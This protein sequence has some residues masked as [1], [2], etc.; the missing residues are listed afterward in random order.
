MSLAE[1]ERI[2]A[3]VCSQYTFAPGAERTIEMNPE[4]A[5][6]DKLVGLRRMGFN[7]VS[8][9]VQ[10]FHEEA[11]RSI[12]RSHTVEKA[13]E[14]VMNAQKAGF[15]NVSVDLILGLP[16]CGVAEVREDVCRAAALPVTHVSVYML[17]I[18][19]GSVLER[20][21]AKGLFTPPA[22]D[23]LA[24]EYRTASEILREN[25]FEHYE[26]SN[27]AREGKRAVHNMN[28][29]RGLPYI[30]FG[31]AAHSYDGTSRQWN[32]AHVLS[33]IKGINK[34]KVPFE[35]EELSDKD[36]YNEYVMTSLRTTDGASLQKLTD[37]YS[38]YWCQN[39]GIVERFIQKG[40]MQQKG[41]ILSLSE[42]GWLL[43]DAIYRDLF[44]V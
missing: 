23:L 25:G 7:R 30:G 29:W 38:K 19:S 36:I 8:I 6:M 40:W 44:V 14:S 31:A 28:Y 10:S 24:D 18:D 1:L 3:A 15:D 42:E 16:G 5:N 39:E 33:Y 12:H 9:G 34:N 2:V 17:S 35:R 11:L 41:D 26:I 4:D 43:S 27:F 37:E 20:Q 22:D 13:I 32:I 21:V